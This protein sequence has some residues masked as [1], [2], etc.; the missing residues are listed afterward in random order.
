M[1][2]IFNSL[3]L[4]SSFLCRFVPPVPLPMA[5][6][7][8]E[9]S[10]WSVPLVSAPPICQGH[11][12]HTTLTAFQ[13][14]TQTRLVFMALDSVAPNCL[15]NP[16][17]HSCLAPPSPLLHPCLCTPPFPTLNAPFFLLSGYHRG[18]GKTCLLQEELGP[19]QRNMQS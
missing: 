19:L 7:S 5:T 16:M 3:F 15:S 9:L 13:G 4:G 2:F 17:F 8:Q 1:P 6:P 12:H 14:V 18:P 10:D 11:H